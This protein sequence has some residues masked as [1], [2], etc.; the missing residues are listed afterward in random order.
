VA[1]A[2]FGLVETVAPGDQANAIGAVTTLGYGGFV[3]SPVLFGWIATA[4]DPRAAMLLIVASSLGIIVA[5]MRTHD[6][7]PEPA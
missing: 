7:A 1:P 6:R 2:G 5:G 4:F 3:V